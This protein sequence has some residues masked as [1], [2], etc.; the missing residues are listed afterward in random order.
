MKVG[1][2][3]EITE[4]VD[5]KSMPYDMRNGHLLEHYSESKDEYM[6]ILD[7]DLVHLIRAYNK[8][9]YVKRHEL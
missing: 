7:M 2:L 3:L 8:T 1:D 4:I 9:L 5:G 6:S